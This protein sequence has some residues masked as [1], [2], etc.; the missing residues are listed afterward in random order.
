MC[1]FVQK[2][3]NIINLD[4][5]TVSKYRYQLQFKK[6]N[7]KINLYIIYIKWAIHVIEILE[8]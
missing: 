1:I 3:N 5:K 4:I 7:I 2:S 6:N 8:E